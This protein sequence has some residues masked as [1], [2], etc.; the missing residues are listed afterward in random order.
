M[1]D[2][3]YLNLTL[4]GKKR[5]PL[6]LI[7]SAMSIM[8][9]LAYCFATPTVPNY[10]VQMDYNLEWWNRASNEKSVSKRVSLF[11]E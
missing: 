8:I 2:T 1:M 7:L 3:G 5:L 10:K 6:I 11:L 9:S 4:K